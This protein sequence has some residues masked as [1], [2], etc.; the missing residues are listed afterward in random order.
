MNKYAKMLKTE[1]KLVFSRDGHGDFCALPA[2]SG[3]GTAR[4]HVWKSARFR[5]EQAI[6]F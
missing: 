3:S 2:G 6:P 5:G 4:H 1:I